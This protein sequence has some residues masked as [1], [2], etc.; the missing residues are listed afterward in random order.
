MAVEPCKEMLD[1]LTGKSG[2]SHVEI[3]NGTMQEFKT[4]TSFD[5]AICVFT[6]LLYLLDEKS[7]K[8]SIQAAVNALVPDGLLL[9]DIPGESV[10]RSYRIKTQIMDR[11]VS[12][13][14]TPQDDIYQYAEHIHLNLNGRIETYTDN[15]KIKYWNKEKVMQIL[16]EN[17]FSVEK[18]LH[19]E[20]DRT[21]SEYFLMKKG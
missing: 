9:I 1:Q 21:G 12:I 3:F 16:V 2:A 13:S 14:E 5:M 18:N 20:F 4:D 7:L 6:V 8:K 10:F 19:F 15:F 11:S 17:G